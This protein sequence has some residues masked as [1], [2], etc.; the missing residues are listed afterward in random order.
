VRS[1]N[2]CAGPAMLPT[3]V[4]RKA[5]QELLDYQGTGTSIMEMSHRSPWFDEVI[6]NAKASLRRLMQ[7][8][9][10]HEI[11]FMHG[12]ATSQF[13]SIP[14]QFL[15]GKNA[16]YLDTGQWSAKAIDAAKR[17][18][19]VDVLASTADS[20]YRSVPL[21]AELKGSNDYAYLHYTPNETI[22][23]LRFDYVPE[24]DAPLIADYSSSILSE[25]IDVSKYDFIYAGAQKNIGPSGVVLVIASKDF[26]ARAKAPLNN[27][28]DYQAQLAGDSRVNTPP[29][30]PIYLAGLVFDWL[31]QKGGV[32]AL[33]GQNVKKAEL[34]YGFI[35]DSDLFSNPITK[36]N[37]SLMNVPFLLK[38]Q[39]LEA[40]FLTLA[41]E[42]G[43]YNL[44]GH[45]SVGGMRAS[46]YNAMP[47]DGVQAL[48]EFMGQFERQY[49]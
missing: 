42:A 25:H 41:Q 24:T 8:P 30:Y 32:N 5:Q 1:F 15:C 23:G 19:N 36:A 31:E 45:R 39:S 27:V 12:G 28:F 18:G 11:L 48:V 34:L 43:L 46:I 40:Q 13:Y 7:I 17:Y 38:D 22:G 33:Y 47:I 35:D 16:A 6:F 14:E 29:T 20:G 49:G 10:S 21:A 9:Q 37:R 4:L 3:E 44:A 2:F 26:L